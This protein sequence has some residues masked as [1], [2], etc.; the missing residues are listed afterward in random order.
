[1]P[2]L[3]EQ[4]ELIGFFSYSRDDDEDSNGALSA[5]RERIQRELRGQLG[6][7]MK[8]FRLWQDKES[9][10]P[11]KLWESEIKA[12]VQQAVFFIPIITPTVVRSQNCRFELETF[13]TREAELGR[14]DLVFPILYIRVP[15]LEDASLQRGDSVLPII[16]KRQYLDWREL[17]HRDVNSPDVREAIERFCAKICEALRESSPSPEERRR[18]QAAALQRADNEKR[19]QEAE[20]KRNTG[21]YRSTDT[22]EAAGS[23]PGGARP[24]TGSF[25]AA[26]PSTGSFSAARPSTGSFS[27]PAG[28]ATAARATLLGM[29]AAR[30]SVIVGAAALAVA[31]MVWG[32]LTLF[33]TPPTPVLAGPSAGQTPG[34]AAQPGAEHRSASAVSPEG[35]SSDPSMIMPTPRLYPGR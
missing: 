25:S 3:T 21:G 23:R 18:Q 10:S 31:F 32:A 20:R 17:R 7:T 11:G 33:A 24:S 12:A 26:R 19:R 30:L 4:S 16:A 22:P 8:T 27:A 1:M 15:E 9:I 34:A 2:S 28:D 14:K 6:R 35:D 29:P 13:L 5:L